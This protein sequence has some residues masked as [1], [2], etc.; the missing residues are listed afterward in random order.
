[1]TVRLLNTRCVNTPSVRTCTLQLCPPA[2]APGQPRPPAPSSLDL[3]PHLRRVAHAACIG[4]C[5]HRSRREIARETSISPP[6]APSPANA[7]STSGGRSTSPHRARA[8]R[9][10]SRAKRLFRH[11]NPEC[12]MT[13]SAT[14]FLRGVPALASPYASTLLSQ[15]NGRARRRRRTSAPLARRIW[16]TPELAV[17]RTA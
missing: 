7:R 2:M 15:R 14:P 3:D 12:R 11:H 8:Q 10:K 6:Q 13:W 5:S 9:L 1:M 17:A 4:A 16:I